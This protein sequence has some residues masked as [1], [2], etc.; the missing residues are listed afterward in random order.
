MCL[1]H[2]IIY[3]CGHTPEKTEVYP[4]LEK[5]YGKRC[6]RNDNGE[7]PEKQC[8]SCEKRVQVHK[9]KMQSAEAWAGGMN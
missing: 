4:C 1:K 9:A 7:E 3:K 2:L 5:L 8:G 6:K